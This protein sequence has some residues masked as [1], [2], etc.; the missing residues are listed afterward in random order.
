M[1]YGGPTNKVDFVINLGYTPSYNRGAAR[2]SPADHGAGK[3]S[4]G[5]GRRMK[6]ESGRRRQS[7]PKPHQSHPKAC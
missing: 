1:C 4:K 3:P 6:P 5:E 2:A 7:H